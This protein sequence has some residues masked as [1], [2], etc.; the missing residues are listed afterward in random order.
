MSHAKNGLPVTTFTTHYPCNS[1][2]R[3]QLQ[4]QRKLANRNL[5][6][7]QKQ[8]QN[9]RT[10]TRTQATNWNTK[11]KQTLQNQTPNRRNAKNRQRIL[12]VQAKLMQSLSAAATPVWILKQRLDPP[13][14]RPPT[15]TLMPW[16][17]HS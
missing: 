16:S 11:R 13:H 15:T 3:L 10:Q 12:F 2:F 8:K 9:S 4:L 14:R 5:P 6:P 7:P 1:T 17:A